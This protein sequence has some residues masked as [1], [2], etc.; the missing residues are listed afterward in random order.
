[1][2]EPDISVC[3]ISVC[4]CACRAGLVGQAQTRVVDGSLL[5]LLVLNNNSFEHETKWESLWSIWGSF[6]I[7]RTGMRLKSKRFKNHG[8]LRS[9]LRMCR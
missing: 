1:M 6:R 4:I 9:I 3:G 8:Y 2:T 7:R 5:R